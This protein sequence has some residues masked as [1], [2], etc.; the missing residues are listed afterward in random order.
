MLCARVSICLV[1][2][3]V[4]RTARELSRFPHAVHIHKPSAP[5]DEN[6]LCVGQR[7]KLGTAGKDGRLFP[8]VLC[9][10]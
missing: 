5:G 3:L 8:K 10:I 2:G 4:S 1:P 9:N 7:L 6:I